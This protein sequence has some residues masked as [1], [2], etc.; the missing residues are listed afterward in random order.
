MLNPG[1]TKKS[2]PKQSKLARTAWTQKTHRRREGEAHEQRAHRREEVIG[3][4][5][6]GTAAAEDAVISDALALEC[7][8]AL[9]ELR[10]DVVDGVMFE[11]GRFFDLGVEAQVLEFKALDLRLEKA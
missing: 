10:V 5:K 4:A 7:I 3:K 8:I 2:R 9:S 11:I 6:K 1:E